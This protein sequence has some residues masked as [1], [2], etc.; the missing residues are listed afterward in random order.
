RK[1]LFVPFRVQGHHHQDKENK[2]KSKSHL[3]PVR[4]A[5]VFL[6]GECSFH[7]LNSCHKLCLIESVNKYGPVFYGPRAAGIFSLFFPG[8][9]GANLRGDPSRRAAACAYPA[10]GPQK[11]TCAP[12]PPF[13]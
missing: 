6:A 12:A 13:R 4:P 8:V 1:Y 11:K 7:I 9:R 2:R 3:L 5:A 10:G